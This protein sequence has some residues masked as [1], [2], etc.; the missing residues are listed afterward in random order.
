MIVN[1]MPVRPIILLWALWPGLA[2]R[3][4][5]LL[6]VD[7]FLANAAQQVEAEELTASVVAGGAIVQPA[8]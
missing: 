2:L 3:A 8:R 5:R 1:P 6:Q 7:T 4:F